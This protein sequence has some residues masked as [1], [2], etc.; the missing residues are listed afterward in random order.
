MATLKHYY[1]VI[2]DYVREDGTTGA[3]LMYGDTLTEAISRGFSGGTYYCGL[4]YRVSLTVL[5]H[6][7]TCNGHGKAPK[8]RSRLG[9]KVCPDCKGRNSETTI[10]DRALLTPSTNMR[11]VQL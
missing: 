5:Q 3:T 8:K 4:G 9:Y 10:V 7:A 2:V 11:I 1:P 6:C